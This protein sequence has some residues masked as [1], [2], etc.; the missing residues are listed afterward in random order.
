[1]YDESQH[2][3]KFH[4]KQNANCFLINSCCSTIRVN[5]DRDGQL[6]I[7]GRWSMASTPFDLFSKNT[8]LSSERA[9]FRQISIRKEKAAMRVDHL[10]PHYVLQNVCDSI[11][12]HED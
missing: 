12:L 1:M 8:S 2:S 10:Q 4:C 7:I 9:I 5:L 3:L 11:S 6:L